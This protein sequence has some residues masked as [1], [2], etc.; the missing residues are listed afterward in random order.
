VAKDLLLY[1]FVGNLGL[2]NGGFGEK[3]E[4]GGVLRGKR[5]SSEWKIWGREGVMLN[6]GRGKFSTHNN[7]AYKANHDVALLMQ[8]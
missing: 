6:H 8:G 7:F 5:D 3:E 2:G 1:I 4:R